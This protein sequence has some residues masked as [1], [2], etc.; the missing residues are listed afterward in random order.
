M[1]KQTGVIAL[2]LLAGAAAWGS[3]QIR[4]QVAVVN[5]AVPVRV[6]NGSKFVE[7]LG[8]DD[9]EVREDGSHN[10]SRPST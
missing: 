9:F 4:H 8:L 6:F 7:T 10:G 1:I 3:G 5:I 2:A